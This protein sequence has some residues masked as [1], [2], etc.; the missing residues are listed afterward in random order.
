MYRNT[1]VYVNLSNLEYNVRTLIKRYEGYKYYFGVVKA[2]CYGHYGMN[3]VDSIIKA[4]C[5]Y[6]AVATL[7][8]AIVIR[9]QRPN[10]NIPILCLGIIDLKYIDVCV[11]NNITVTISNLEY[12]KKLESNDKLKVHIKVNSGMN[13]LGVNNSKD[14]NEVYKAIKDK[15]FILEG[16]YTHIY[17]A[18]SEYNT[19]KQYQLFEEITKDIDLS[20]IPIVHVGASEATELYEKRPYANGC[21]LGIAM[22]GLIDYKNI[23]FKSTFSLCSEVIQINE[24]QNGIV[25][26]SG[27]YKVGN[28]KERIAVIPIG[29]ADGIIRKN[30]GRTVF[31]NNKEYEIVGNV[32]M[33][34][35]FVRVDESVKVGDKVEIIKDIDHIKKIAKYLDTIT[36]EVICSIGKRVPRIYVK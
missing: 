26:Y 8:E 16:I 3:P 19:M 20:M 29:Y 25:G 1:C 15:S 2:D 28:K 17:D 12:V 27:K 24:V 34:M 5:N 18:S 14:F 21:R 36:Y 30:S 31:I 22:Y 23:E 4:G 9:E 35:L 6:L 13:R 33:D 7:D 11:K 32:C 10:L